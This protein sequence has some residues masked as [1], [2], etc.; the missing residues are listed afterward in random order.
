[1]QRYNNVWINNSGVPSSEADSRAFSFDIIPSSQLDNMIVVKSPAP[2]IPS[3]FSGGF[4][5]IQTKDV[6]DQNSFSIGIGTT[7][8]DATHFQTSYRSKGSATDFLGF[9]N[10]FRSKNLS[11]DSRLDNN[12]KSAV[13]NFTKNGLNNDW[14]IR[15][16][17]PI[18]DIKL[19]AAYN[20]KFSTDSGKESAILAA[21]NYTEGSK[22][23]SD[24][25]NARYGIYNISTDQPEYLYNYNDNRYDQNWRLGGMLNFTFIP[26]HGNKYEFKN[27]VNQLATDRYTTRTG[28]QFIS[29]RYDQEKYEY[30]Y[31]SR[32]TYSGQFTGTHSREQMK[33]D[34]SAGYAYSNKNQPDRRI[35]NREE[36][37]FVSDSH[38]GE[39][40]I[41]QNEIQ[42]E[43]SRLNEHIFSAAANYRYDFSIWGIKPT[44]KTG[45]YEEYRT[46][47]FKTR[48]FYYR[49]KSNN[50]PSDFSY[51][52]VIDDILIDS[53]FDAE[54]LYLYEDTDNRN[55]Y[56]GN[57][58]LTAV[59][60]GLNIPIGK[61]EA[62]GGVRYEYNKMSLKSYTTLKGDK[63]KTTEY[64]KG[65]FFPSV[66]A[67]YRF[68][69][70]HQL[71]AAYGASV[72]RPEF[73]EL[74]GSVYYDFDLFSDVKGNANLKTAY[75]QNIDFRYEYYPNNGEVISV[76]LFYK[77]F[78]NPIEW[79]YL[80]AGGSYT[81]TFE[82]AKRADNYGVELE[83]RK[84]L[85]FIGLRD[86]SVNFNGSL[87]KSKVKFDEGSL[88]QDRAM[89]GQ[90]PYL[91]NA[92]IFYQHPR[93]HFN[94]GAMYNRIG[95]RIIGVGRVD[96]SVGGNIN[97]NI[98][99]SY[100]MP[101]NAVDLTFSK[102]FGKI[103]EIKAS[104]TDILGEKLEYVQFP[105]FIDENGNYQKR[106]QVTKSFSPGRNFNLS[107]TMNF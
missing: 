73:R 20:R 43:F 41:D 75:I 76:A 62:Y 94:I 15:S 5:Q 30:H 71:R 4:I 58:S 45:I 54:K 6:P 1:S 33:I 65:D 14:K 56:S 46:R 37:G 101:R 40:Q 102:K 53:N 51:G 59:Y 3:D 70:K 66:N 26:K 83:I 107:V 64:P 87:I 11:Y 32:T 39:M 23:Y 69:E 78:K 63:T 98:P 85:D 44:L 38:F 79:T 49:W 99:D 36:N 86:F 2:E 52:D 84:N 106:K 103:F 29:G 42:R 35:I 100:E 72:N 81:F 90:S 77:N 25:K 96:T 55:S 17:T 80:D 34:W 57:N 31:N 24:M 28:Y 16:H 93:Y 48:S 27:I 10:G 88:E 82:N 89:Q 19:N 9:D 50:L 74:S 7:I 60:A 104:A 67:A 68:N 105:E 22:T 91:V 92:G 13:S 21:I 95:K 47:D 18:G 8:N 12:D 61:F 97:N